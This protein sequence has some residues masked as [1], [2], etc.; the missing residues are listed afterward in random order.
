MPTSDLNAL[1][2]QQ[3][4]KRLEFKRDLSSPVP[5]AKTLVAF[6]VEGLVDWPTHARS[7]DSV[8]LQDAELRRPEGALSRAEEFE[9]EGRPDERLHQ[10]PVLAL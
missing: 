3:E 10:T 1:L 7:G 9:L 2:R 6:V 5:I 8:V 4:G